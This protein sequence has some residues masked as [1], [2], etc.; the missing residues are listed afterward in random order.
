MTLHSQHP[1]LLFSQIAEKTAPRQLSYT[2][3]IAPEVQ[4]AP[5]HPTIRSAQIFGFGQG[6]FSNQKINTCEFATGTVTHTEASDFSARIEANRQACLYDRAHGRLR[7]DTAD[8]IVASLKINQVGGPK[9]LFGRPLQRHAD[10]LAEAGAGHVMRNI[11]IS[12]PVIQL[13]ETL[14]DGHCFNWQ[15]HAAAFENST[16]VCVYVAIC[17]GL[18]TLAKNSKLTLAKIGISRR[19]DVNLRMME[20]NTDQYGSIGHVNNVWQQDTGYTNWEPVR[21]PTSSEPT[22][23]SPVE[24]LPRSLLVALP[25]SLSVDDFDLKL[26]TALSSCILSSWIETTDGELHCARQNIDRDM[27]KRF[28]AHQYAD[29]KARLKTSEEIYIFRKKE[30]TDLLVKAIEGIIAAHLMTA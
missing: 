17:D 23:P 15:A 29:G 7:P 13:D 6:S 19:L 12:W 4:P 11:W 8:A 28:T 21:L 9:D 30:H 22:H 27:L 24:R 3:S 26:K 20:I 2:H 16:S 1:I 10:A 25:S 5:W 18:C 14:P